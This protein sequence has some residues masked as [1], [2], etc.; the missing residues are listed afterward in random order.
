MKRE[1][2][3]WSRATGIKKPLNKDEWVELW[4]GDVIK[5]KLYISDRAGGYLHITGEVLWD[6]NYGM[7]I[8]AGDY[9]TGEGKYHGQFPLH[10]I[11]AD[12]V[13]FIKKVPRYIGS[14][15]DLIFEII[16]MLRSY[17]QEPTDIYDILG[18]VSP[19]ARDGIITYSTED[20][21]TTVDTA[22][23]DAMETIVSRIELMG[24]FSKEEIRAAFE[25]EK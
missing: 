13:E 7:Y 2:G 17:S 16:S 22:L 18:T 5:C 23:T 24:L 6:V 19:D 3:R 4:V 25:K 20:I 8:I 21:Q 1:I 11:V 15:R 9:T 12:P 10:E 14:Q